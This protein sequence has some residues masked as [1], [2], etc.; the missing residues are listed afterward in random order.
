MKQ[1]VLLYTGVSSV[2][3]I[4]AVALLYLNLLP[5]KYCI[6]TAARVLHRGLAA[7]LT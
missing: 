2:T 3:I 7:A 4:D 5:C 1:K 6:D